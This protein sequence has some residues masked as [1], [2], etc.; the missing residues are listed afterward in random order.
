M[1]I[2]RRLLI[3]L[4]L[5]LP[6][7]IQASNAS[8]SQATTSVFA[9]CVGT[10]QVLPGGSAVCVGEIEGRPGEWVFLSAGHVFET[11]TRN[12]NLVVNNQP[13]ESTVVFRD[14]RADVAILVVR[15]NARFA[16]APV[17]RGTYLG[18]VS[19]CGYPTYPGGRQA[20]WFGTATGNQI[21]LDQETCHKLVNGASGGGVFAESGELIGILTHT[22]HASPA[23]VD[24]GTYRMVFKPVGEFSAGFASLGWYPRDWPDAPTPGDTG[25]WPDISAPAE[26]ASGDS[27]PISGRVDPL[28]EATPSDPAKIDEGDDAALQAPIPAQ[29]AQTSPVD[30]ALSSNGSRWRTVGRTVALAAI[31]IAAPELSLPIMAI[32]AV[33]GVIGFI[34]NRRKKRRASGGRPD[35]TFQQGQASRHQPRGGQYG[36]AATGHPSTVNGHSR[37]AQVDQSL[38]TTARPTPVEPSIGWHGIGEQRWAKTPDGRDVPNR[39]PQLDPEATIRPDP[40]QVYSG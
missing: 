32:T 36:R 3:S 6:E 13:V 22:A 40:Q 5:L 15:S 20:A 30:E 16:K 39:W 23:L 27:V 21:Q 31:K 29:S 34:S 26:L 19:V 10:V 8:Q 7:M 24:F 12:R 17:W 1:K 37:P 14:E 28:P 18:R 11:D 33:G 4:C 35:E 9:S 25:S 2:A 38:S